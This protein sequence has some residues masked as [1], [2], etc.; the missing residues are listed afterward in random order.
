MDAETE[1]QSIEHKSMRVTWF[2]LTAYVHGG[3]YKELH[4]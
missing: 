1:A 2:S 3:N 4:L